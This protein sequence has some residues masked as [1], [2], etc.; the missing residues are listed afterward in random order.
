MVFMGTCQGP[1]LP[2]II[3]IAGCCYLNQGDAV[4]GYKAYGK[5]PEMPSYLLF[6][7]KPLSR[8]VSP[9]SFACF[10]SVCFGCVYLSFFFSLAWEL[11]E[12]AFS[13]LMSDFCFGMCI[14]IGTEGLFEGWGS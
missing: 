4:P 6:L 1:S 5:H 3:Y 7:K 9:G 14:G 12:V 13:P 11:L 8:P 10:F 2:S